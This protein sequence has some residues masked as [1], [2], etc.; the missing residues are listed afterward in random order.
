MSEQQTTQQP[1]LSEVEVQM[2]MQQLRSQQNLVAG[3]LAGLVA[4]LVGA[5]VWALISALTQYQ[6]G[7]MAIGIGLLVGFAVRAI[8]KGVD[9]VFGIVAAALS[10]V[11]CVLG[12]LL[13]MMYF[14]AE[15]EQMPFLDL[16]SRMD[17]D[18]AVNIMAAT[19]D[20]MDI[21]FYAIA[22]YFGYK[23]AFRHVT[24]DELAVLAGKAT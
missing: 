4:A 12:N 3:A 17:L 24:R 15:K 23:Y 13:T 10:L 2:A 5:G 19:F 18:L 16:V 7:W 14:I 20:V 8:G 6:I 22:L 11:G 21:V 1:E 9:P